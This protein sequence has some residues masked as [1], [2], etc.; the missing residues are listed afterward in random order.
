MEGR[1]GKKISGVSR[2]CTHVCMC[3]C[4]NRDF[5]SFLNIAFPRFE[6]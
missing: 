4:T 3:L 1:K 6:F 5:F 2:V